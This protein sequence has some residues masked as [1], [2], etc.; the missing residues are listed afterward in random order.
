M[1][2][3]ENVVHLYNALRTIRTVKEAVLQIV[4]TDGVI[5]K[6]MAGVAVLSLVT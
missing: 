4:S 5:R 3:K 2:L 6:D 1:R